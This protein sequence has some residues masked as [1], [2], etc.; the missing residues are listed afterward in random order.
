MSNFNN[1][2]QPNGNYGDCPISEI[3]A[4]LMAELAAHNALLPVYTADGSPE[5]KQ[6]FMEFDYKTHEKKQ[7]ALQD[8][9]AELRDA[10]GTASNT[11][12]TASNTNTNTSSGNGNDK[13]AAPD[14]SKTRK[15]KVQTMGSV[16]MKPVT[17]LWRKVVPLGKLTIF[18]GDPGNMKSL[19]AGDIAARGSTN[20]AMPDGT[21]GQ[22]FDTLMLIGEDDIEDTTA[23]RLAAA[24][25]DQKHI[26]VL[27][28]TVLK[29][30]NS[31]EREIALDT[32]IGMLREYLKANPSI[33]LVI[34]DPVSNYLGGTNMIDEKGMR[35]QVLIP[36][37]KLAAEVN[38]AMLGIMH[39]NKKVTL[40]AI[41]RVGG[42]MAFV[43]VARM[44]WMFI[45]DRED[46]DRL[47]MLQVKNNLTKSI[48]GFAFQ[49]TEKDILIEGELV[50]QPVIQWMGAAAQSV[51]QHLGDNGNGNGNEPRPAHRPKAA[52]GTPSAQWLRAY[53]GDGKE[54]PMKEVMKAARLDRGYSPATVYRAKETTT[55]TATEREEIVG[56]K[57]KAVT[58]WRMIIGTT[59]VPF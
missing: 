43:G 9:I 55:I 4:E 34:V 7:F 41:N 20:A 42:A 19:A 8:R 37:K 18:C 39:L 59:E 21:V 29:G 30:S 45:R 17:W 1:N 14:S 10:N 53:M 6:A 26:L 23:P 13:K 33:K 28:S 58:Y 16:A 2:A 44:V 40:G 51:N 47:Y 48:K 22:Q 27:H 32:D 50:S 11:T 12:A 46:N 15:F 24:G 5:S 49:A 31:Q 54:R 25:A 35:A 38:V 56:G 3:L 52:N 57:K 36:L